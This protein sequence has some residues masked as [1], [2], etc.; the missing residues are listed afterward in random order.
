[1]INITIKN[2]I[3]IKDLPINLTNILVQGL[4]VPNPKFIDAQ[5][6]GYSTYNI[7]QYINNFSFDPNNNLL[8]PRGYR[9]ELFELLKKNN[10]PYTTTDL[11]TKFSYI[12]LD[13]SQIVYRP[14]QKEAVTELVLHDEGMLV[15]P[16][17][18]GKT[19]MGLSLIPLLGQPTLWIT[20]TGPLLAQ[21]KAR[22]EEFL[23][24]LKI[25]LIS[26]GKWETG[27]VLTIGMVQ[28]LIKNPEKLAEIQNKFGL[29]IQD[30]C[31]H[32]PATTFSKVNSAFFFFPIYY[33]FLHKII[34]LIIFFQKYKLY[35]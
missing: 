32:A 3:Q 26:E 21:A 30:E 10:A 17:G 20:H 18:S 5:K 35:L 34:R 27:D 23:P 33:C 25:G 19:V 29:V 9:R 6:L 16:A 8:I 4:K 15:S 1:M 11:R 14:Y 7:D 12:S 31:Q 24:G 2:K 13:S 28:T 22:A